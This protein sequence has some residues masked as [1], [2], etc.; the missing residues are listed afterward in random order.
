M[1]TVGSRLMRR[2]MTVIDWFIPAQL[3]HTP[4]LQTRAQNIIN[5]VVM[6][7]LVG[8]TF[9]SF[10]YYLDFAAGAAMILWSCVPMLATPFVLRW[11]G[12]MRLACEVFVA[13]CFVLFTWLSVH[14]GGVTSPAAPWMIVPPIVAMLI[15]GMRSAL[16]WTSASCIILASMFMLPLLG[17]ALPLHRLPDI[18]ALHLLSHALLIILTVIFVLLFEITRTQGFIRLERALNFINEL[19]IRDEL[20]GVYNRR[21]LLALIEAERTR[22]LRA[23]Q[24]FCL[25]LLDIDF[26]KRVNDSYGHPAG[27]S[28]LRAFASA[29]S[30]QV[31]DSDCFGRYGGEEFLLMLPETS[32]DAAAALVERI[33]TAVEA[34]RFAD[35]DAGLTMTV[36]IGVAQFRSGETIAQGI[37]RADEALYLAKAR[38]RNRV[39]FHGQAAALSIVPAAEVRHPPSSLAGATDP[40]R[41]QLTGLPNRA[42]LHQRLAAALAR[43]REAG[44][45]PRCGALLLI[46]VNKFREVN[47]ALGFDG[48]DAMLVQ[49]AHRVCACLHDADAM[50]RWSGDQLALVLERLEREEDVLQVAH[51]IL[52]QFGAPLALAGRD[53]FVNLS[54]G[55]AAFANDGTCDPDGLIQRADSAMATAKTWGDNRVQLY[56][57]DTAMPASQ[58]LSLK[59]ALRTALGNEELFI[60][61][62]PQIDLA[63]TRMIGV[64]AL[65][66]WNHPLLGRVEPS[67]FIA[68]AEETGLIVPIGE[69]VLRSACLQNRAWVDAGLP[70]LTMAVNVS[71]RQLRQPQLVERILQIIADTGI[72]AGCLD[73][74]ITEGILIDDLPALVPGLARLRRAGVKIS[75][76]DFGTGYSSLG[77]LAELPADILK[78]DRSFVIRLGAEND[79]DALARDRSY[80]LARAIIEL[81]HGLNLKVVAE[82]VETD[83]QRA[84]LV[85]MR[86]DT[87]QGYLF[88]RPL[89][90]D[91]VERLLR[92]QNALAP[93][94][95][96]A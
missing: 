88:D 20:T 71:A 17:V 56:P 7:A 11:S 24:P 76:D 60:E 35:V 51:N 82:A 85:A 1:K 19:A 31:R 72:D 95:Q 50:V 9:A 3:Q 42:V 29:A 58:R 34:L 16:F 67:R 68:L 47:E 70:A 44:T 49:I 52:A 28:V 13:A 78:M 75:I 14:L 40:K 30:A 90:P 39:V 55:I 48:G 96:V 27:D 65:V 80:A 63:S 94:L 77:Y 41:D 18:Q 12:S 91:Q 23:G 38:G 57:A 62:Q 66:R 43:M 83:A 4:A 93:A 64:E 46:N 37:A 69:W 87:A 45:E 53:Y 5:A 79:S 22:E 32:L 6:A 61:Y 36:S 21:H 84:D 54:I 15:G 89:H 86:C 92:E 10:Y 2:Y 26:F 74:E 73:L 81:A 8:P 33:R 59:T 25:C